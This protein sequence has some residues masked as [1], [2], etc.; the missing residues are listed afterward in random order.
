MISA[1]CWVPKG[2]SK[3][4]PLVAEPP[5]KEEIEEVLRTG[6]LERKGDIDEEEDECMDVD[7]APEVLDE[8]SIARAATKALNQVQAGRESRDLQAVSVGIEELNMDAY[9][10]E[11]D[12]IELFASGIGD[13][14]YPSND[15]DPYLQNKG[16]DEDDDDDEIEDM[17][18]KPTDSVIVCARNED[19]VS[20]LEVWIF[21]DS[22]DGDSNMYVH[23][24]VILPAFPLCTAWLD[25]NLKGGDKGNFLAVG[26]LEPAIEIWDLDLIDEV[27]PFLVLG[28]V[29]NKK[30]KNKKKSVI[31]R[32]DSHKDSVLGLAWN[33]EVR[34]VLA[35]ASADKSVK[36]WDVVT[37]K[38]V[39]TTA[40]HSDKVQ[41]V[42]WNRFSPELLLSG[43]FDRSVVMVD[44]RSI[45]EVS[46]KW[47]VMAD[48]EGLAWDPHADHSFVVSQENGVVQGFDI[49]IGSSDGSSFKPVFTLHAH[50]KAVSSI[51][52]NPCRPN[53]LATGST[54]KT[55]KL[56]DL[57]NSQPSCVASTKPK[58]GSIFSIAFSEDNPFLLAVGG[59]KGK[60][61]IWDVT[62]E[63]GIARS[64]EKYINKGEGPA[65]SA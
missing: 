4:V 18:I 56:W 28:G 38:C 44:G 5:S 53:L 7:D 26:S 2:A 15:M 60:L 58:A 46:K 12:G 47:P 62:S 20:H 36:I 54:D 48:V 22:G 61:K 32:K 51:S 45:N 16:D 10:D 52:Y 14:Y 17:T 30:K 65:T 19:E 49:R 63:P 13:T 8:V 34:N 6:V 40:H 42:A 27:Q 59:H 33:K 29:S 1:V 25:C 43:S 37:G 23:H 41:S 31:Y 50:D 11:D 35:S 3:V 64:F 24:D 55:V 39:A 9:D 57:S 21:E